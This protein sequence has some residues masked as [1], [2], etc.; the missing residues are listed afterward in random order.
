LVHLTLRLHL[1][2]SQA[3]YLRGSTNHINDYTKYTNLSR[4]DWV[5]KHLQVTIP[6][7]C[8]D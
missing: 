1:L 2:L 4:F 6:N 7:I 5:Q 3:S 8:W